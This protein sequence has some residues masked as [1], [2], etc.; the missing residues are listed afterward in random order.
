MSKVLVLFSGGLDSL[1]TAKILQEK[2]YQVEAVHFQNPFSKLTPARVKKIA[3]QLDL[4]IYF[5]K[6]SEDYLRLI[7]SPR[8][9]YGKNMNPCLDCR[10]FLLKKSWQLGK[11]VGVEFL[12][13]GEVIGQRPFSQRRQA[14]AL[15]EKQAGLTG[16]ILRP[17]ADFG[18]RG[19]GR[20]Q[21]LALA[22]QYQLKNF[23]TP[24]G[25]CLLTD[26]GFS[27][28]LRAFL[29]HGGKL[30]LPIVGLLKLGRHFWQEKNLMV[31]G[32]HEKENQ[33]LE[34]LARRQ[35]WWFGEVIDIPSPVAVV[36]K[37]AALAPAS[38][39][40]I[41]YSDAEPGE[42]AVCQWQKGKKK[43]FI[44]INGLMYVEM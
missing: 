28:R 33:K 8:H 23:L 12:A 9:G 27:Q 30:N 19:R 15:I 21:Q 42:K 35:N 18:I 2:N 1:L 10:I 24:A 6:L 16:K 34:K 20:H 13:T 40:L 26:P 29:D 3:D 39:L 38:E 11:K 14:L 32:R 22:R 5:I 25:G 41:R 7:E 4:K 17:L 43:K 44:E 36:F 31:I 37:K